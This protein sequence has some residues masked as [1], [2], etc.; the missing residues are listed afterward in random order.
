VI[1]GRAGYRLALDAGIPSP[2]ARLR[3]HVASG[4]IED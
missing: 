3:E 1:Q 4:G 2:Y